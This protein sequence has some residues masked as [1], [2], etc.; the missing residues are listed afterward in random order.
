MLGSKA[1]GSGGTGYGAAS[2][3]PPAGFREPVVLVP[4]GQWL[5]ARA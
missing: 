4:T 2:G 3:F 5:S 1:D